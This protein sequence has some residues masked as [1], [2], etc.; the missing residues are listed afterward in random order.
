V[1]LSFAEIS[2]IVRS[3]VSVVTETSLEE[4]TLESHVYNDLGMEST[5]INELFARLEE[6]FK[7][8]VPDSSIDYFS[9]GAENYWYTYKDMTRTM[10]EIKNAAL[11]P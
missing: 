5:E 3:Q 10:F 4:I 8:R 2:F 9:D 11:V 7:L 1:A 6:A